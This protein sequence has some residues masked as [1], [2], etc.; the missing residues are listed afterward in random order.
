MRKTIDNIR[1]GC[2]VPPMPDGNYGVPGSFITVERYKEAKEMGLDFV[3]GHMEKGPDNP[4]VRQALKCANATGLKYILR[5][6]DMINYAESTPEELKKALGG[7]LDDDALIGVLIRDEPHAREFPRMG[8][9]CDLYKK[10]TDKYFYLNL[11]PWDAGEELLGAPTYADH[12]KEMDK[13]VKNDML[14]MDIYPLRKKPGGVYYVSD[15]FLR[16]LEEIQNFCLPRKMEHWQFVQG[17]MAYGISKAPDYFDMRLQI[18]AS[19][20]Y[21]ATVFQYYCYCTPN[22]PAVIK[23]KKW[24]SMLDYWGNKTKRYYAAQRLCN[25][26]HSLGKELIPF[27]PYWKGV[28]PVIG[29]KNGEKKNAAFDMLE[30]P[31]KKLEGI[32]TVKA[33]QDTIIGSFVKPDGAKAYVITNYTVPAY[34]TKDNVEIVFENAVKAT[35]YIR[36]KK[37]SIVTD[38]GVLKLMLG[39]GEGVLVIPENA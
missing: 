9:I 14:S 22:L 33:E 7:V 23:K 16:N 32:K 12:L 35:V 8:K 24:T 29:E 17:S 2:W 3:I 26:L 18:Y 6:E 21:G 38:G 13:Y 11:F 5:W 36:G 31:L 25:E 30:T 4:D 10:I 19:L 1:F 39:A 34:R 27:E 37:K 20:C 15:C 28:M